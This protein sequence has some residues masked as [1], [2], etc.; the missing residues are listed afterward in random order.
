MIIIPRK[1][2]DLNKPIFK[3][4]NLT[5]HENELRAIERRKIIRE[6]NK[7]EKKDGTIKKF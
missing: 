7:K 3:N 5:K 2:F 4:N 1:R 6:M